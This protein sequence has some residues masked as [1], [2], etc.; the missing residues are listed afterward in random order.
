MRGGESLLT[1]LP[2]LLAVVNSG[3]NY[4]TYLS[5]SHSP[6]SLT[7]GSVDRY[8]RGGERGGDA[9]IVG[10]RRGDGEIDE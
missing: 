9:D 8:K 7:T 2:L 10:E 6:S 3:K 5:V 1:N 4:T